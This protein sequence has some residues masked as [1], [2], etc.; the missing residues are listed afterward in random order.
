MLCVVRGVTLRLTEALIVTIYANNTSEDIC[1]GPQ[2]ET[3]L[4]DCYN[5]TYIYYSFD[6]CDPGAARETPLPPSTSP[7]S[8][9]TPTGAI[10]GGVVGGV[11]ALGIVLCLVWMC[12][13]KKRR[14]SVGSIVQVAEVSGHSRAELEP[15]ELYT[16]RVK[17]ESAAAEVERP[18]VELEGVGMREER[19][20]V[21]VAY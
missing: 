13:V 3:Q 2:K 10:V 4:I 21:G 16:G 11:V 9:K 6:F 12:V 15:Q 17:Y 20:R 14:R 8:P 18:P 7:S 1:S 5:S 19:V